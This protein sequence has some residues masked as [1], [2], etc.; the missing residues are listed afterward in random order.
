MEFDKAKVFTVLNA[1]EVK[2]G[3]SGYFADNLRSL[4]VAAEEECSRAYGE[5]EEIMDNSYGCRFRKKNG[6]TYTLF[7]LAEEPWEKKFRPYKDTDEM[8]EDFKERFNVSVPSYEMPLI[9]VKTKDADKKYL[10]VHFASALTICYN[11]EVFTPTLE[12]LAEDYTF[13]DGS[14]CGIE[15]DEE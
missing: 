3:S 7:Y 4:R 5:I 1:D 11:V 15:E 14:P 13:L 2:I 9:W 12:E 6:D 8:V 10:I